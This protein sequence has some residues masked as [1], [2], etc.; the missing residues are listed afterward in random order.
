ATEST[1]RR[2]EYVGQTPQSMPDAS[3][4]QSLVPAE[5][6]MPR[7][8]PD[9]TVQQA[10]VNVQ[11]AVTQ[12][13]VSLEAPAQQVMQDVAMDQ[14]IHAMESYP[15]ETNVQHEMT[16]LTMPQEVT[17]AVETPE[18]TAELPNYATGPSSAV[19]NTMPEGIDGT[20]LDLPAFDDGSATEFDRPENNPLDSNPTVSPGEI[21]VYQQQVGPGINAFQESSNQFAPAPAVTPAPDLSRL[22]AG[23]SSTA[24][25]NL[26][27]VSSTME[28]SYGPA[29]NTGYTLPYRP[30]PTLE[31]S[32]ESTDMPALENIAEGIAA[33][34][35]ETVSVGETDPWQPSRE[36]YTAPLPRIITVSSDPEPVSDNAQRIKNPFFNR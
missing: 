28:Q 1:N 20:V 27:P 8:A 17:G 6:V 35:T 12:P 10:P 19:T 13:N 16:P 9:T 3:N 34:A 22:E 31:N 15:G 29:F 25:P 33:E 14:T 23:P 36:S 11:P 30:L 32:V 7:Y 5:P 4:A 18:Y 24:D 2:P 21:P 26:L